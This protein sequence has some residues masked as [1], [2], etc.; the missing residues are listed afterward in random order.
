MAIDKE[1]AVEAYG[2][3]TVEFIAGG[4]QR[5]AARDWAIVKA[6]IDAE[7]DRVA[8]SDPPVVDRTAVAIINDADSVLRIVIQDS[9][10]MTSLES[11]I[12]DTVY[13][14]RD[15]TCTAQVNEACDRYDEDGV[16]AAYLDEHPVDDGEEGGDVE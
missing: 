16:L 6:F 1:T 12:W 2:R 8:Q 11:D 4:L 13:R 5:A 15:K 9:N 3:F 14:F 7:A 10:T